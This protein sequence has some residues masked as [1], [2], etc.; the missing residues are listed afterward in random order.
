MIKAVQ[1]FVFI[2]MDKASETTGELWLPEAGREKPTKGTIISVGSMVRDHNI[3]NHKNKEC[4][5]HAGTGFN[6]T[7]EKETYLVVEGEKIIA[8]V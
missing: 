1:N 8:L 6:I 3:K 4:L 7:Y 2:L 5:F